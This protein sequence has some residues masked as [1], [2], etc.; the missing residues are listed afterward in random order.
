MTQESIE[1]TFTEKYS[2]EEALVNGLVR[3][4]IVE[5]KKHSLVMNDKKATKNMEECNEKGG[6]KTKQVIRHKCGKYLYCKAKTSWYCPACPAAPRS[7]R[8]WCCDP[9]QPNRHVCNAKHDSTW[10]FA[11]E[12]ADAE[13]RSE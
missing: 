7:N 2:D 4:I 5:K 11:A 3:S 13:R 1:E 8:H 10:I 9:T 12:R 6:L